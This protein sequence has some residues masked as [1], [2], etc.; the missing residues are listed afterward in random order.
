MNNSNHV[1]FRSYSVDSF[2]YTQE[3]A[4]REAVLRIPLGL[5]IGAEDTEIDHEDFHLGAF[6]GDRL[7]AC[8][9]LRPLSQTLVKL[10]QMAVTPEFQGHG[11]GR[12]L[13]LFAEQFARDHRFVEIEL[14]ARAPVTDFYKK[15]GYEAIGDQFMVVGIPHF[16]MVKVF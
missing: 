6:I 2:D 14:A 15:L 4:L 9:L 1:T 10:R 13:V 3:L 16:K 12:D 8:V 11:I 7:V 5:Q